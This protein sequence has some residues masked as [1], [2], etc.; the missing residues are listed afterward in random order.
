M[1][2]LHW[3]RD[4]N[5][6]QKVSCI[7]IAL[8]FFLIF[9]GS[10]VRASGAGLG[11]PDWPKCFGMWIPPT[12]ASELPAEYDASAFNPVHTWSEYVNRLVG[13]LVGFMITVTFVTSF[14]YRK[15]NPVV[16]YSS[17]AAFVLVLFQGWLGGQVVQSGLI[18]WMITTHMIVALLIVNVLLYAFFK[19]KSSQLK[20]T[21]NRTQHSGIY[22]VALVLIG[23]TLLQIILGAQVREALEG[24]SNAYPAMER[25][26]WL[27]EVGWIDQI[28]RSASWLVLGLGVWLWY[29]ARNY[30]AP[31]SVI[32]LS[33]VINGLIIIQFIGGVALAYFGLPPAFQV[34]H[35][36]FA[37]F[38]IAAQ[39]LL[40]LILNHARQV[41]EKRQEYQNSTTAAA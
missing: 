18:D 39:F 23:V 9:V 27:S 17:L 6:F 7:T 26:A 33:L 28:H 32:K 1:K 12:T 3:F 30:G 8:T 29:R 36:L 4:L 22:M 5:G 31:A 19:A 38:L 41:A 20:I 11:C 34:I 37:S 24:V 40:I 10:F 13:V 2:L 14:T 16:L 25:A 21:L 15:T 35:L